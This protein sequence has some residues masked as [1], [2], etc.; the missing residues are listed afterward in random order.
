MHADL[1]QRVRGQRHVD[2]AQHRRCQPVLADADDGVQVVRLGAQ[3]APL[4]G[5]EVRHA[6]SLPP[7]AARAAPGA[8]YNRACVRARKGRAGMAAW[9]IVR[10]WWWP[11]PPPAWLGQEKLIFFPQPLAGTSHLPRRHP[12]AGGARCGRHAA[13]GLLRARVGRRGLRCCSFSAAMPRRSRGRSPTGAGPTAIARA[14][15]NYR[16]YGASEG[17]PGEAPLVEDAMSVLDAVAARDDVDASRI[18]V[19]GRS[20]GTGI[21]ARVAAERSVR[22]CDPRLALRQPGRGG[23]ARITRGCRSRG[24]SGTGSTR[25]PRRAGATVPMLAVVAG[26]DAIIPVE[27]SRALVRRVGRPE[28]LGRPRRSRAQ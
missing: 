8:P 7:P 12:G 9:L 24:S 16:G 1:D 28:V 11:S 10:R 22:R 5:R 15:V 23:H 17:Q 19:V 27:R 25:S 4:L 20:L 3:R 13:R 26:R 14:G 6:R 21:A 2:L 18:V